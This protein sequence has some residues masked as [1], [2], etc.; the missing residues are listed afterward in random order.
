MERAGL[1]GLG[2]ED[3]A[4]RTRPIETQIAE[5]DHVRDERAPLAKQVDGSL[6]GQ[7]ERQ[8]AVG[9]VEGHRESDEVQP[10]VPGLVG[11]LSRRSGVLGIQDR[12]D[13]AAEPD[14]RELAALELR[15]SGRVE[16]RRGAVVRDRDEGTA[17]SEAARARPDG[18]E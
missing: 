7:L 14:D 13:V 17:H 10:V 12:L 11:D 3:E 9:H 15:E 5:W 8:I 18:V 2:V 4:R 1:L 16:C 6:I